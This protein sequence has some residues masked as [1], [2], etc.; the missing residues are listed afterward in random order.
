MSPDIWPVSENAKPGRVIVICGLPAS[1]K[2]TLAKGLAADHSGVRLCPDEWMHA[3]G[4]DLW[5]RDARARVE[6]LQWSLAEDLLTVGSTVIIEWGVWS[7]AERDTLRIRAHDLGATVELH[8]LDVPLEE[9]WRRMQ[10]RN[11]SGDPSVAIIE[12]EHLEAWSTIF[13]PPTDDE[14]RL[15]DPVP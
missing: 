5:D 11:A 9:L 4:I 1:G 3:L 7:R 10:L 14:L 13:E 6:A 8:Y 15:Y 12:R 2:T